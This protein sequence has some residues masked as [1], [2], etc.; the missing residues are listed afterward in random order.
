MRELRGQSCLG[1]EEI[2]P[3]R[4]QI[5]VSRTFGG[6]VD[7]RQAMGQAL[8]TFL[9]RAA[10]KLRSRGLVAAAVGVFASTDRFKNSTPQHHPSKVVAL[11]SPTADTRLLLAQLRQILSGRFQR[12]GVHYRK[13]GAWLTDLAR[14]QHV[15]EDLFSPATLG[16]EPLMST[17]DA[18]NH[19]FGHGRAGFGASG[20]KMRQEA[21]S[22]RYTTCVGELPLVRW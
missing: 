10:E 13:A 4:Q 12:A 15:H 8:A 11:Q 2:E 1:L 19:R 17:L 21:L 22:R 7:D 16:N 3:D 9:V 20:W 14:P 6:P 18:I 5:M